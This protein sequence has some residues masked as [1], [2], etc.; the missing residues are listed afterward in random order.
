MDAQLHD[1]PLQTSVVFRR[2]ENAQGGAYRLNRFDEVDLLLIALPYWVHLMLELVLGGNT[3]RP[4]ATI[5]VMAIAVWVLRTRFPDGLLPL[6][7]V[8]GM[9]RRLS[10]LARDRGFSAGGYPPLRS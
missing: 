2:L 4:L 6:I 3:I 5:V 1:E 8:L 7:R 9:P 10:S